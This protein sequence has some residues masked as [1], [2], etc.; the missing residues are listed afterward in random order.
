MPVWA[1]SWNV[2]LFRFQ[3]VLAYFRC[4]FF[5]LIS[6]NNC[7]TFN[8]HHLFFAPFAPSYSRIYIIANLPFFHNSNIPPSK[9]NSIHIFPNILHSEA[10]WRELR[11]RFFWESYRDR[12]WR[13]WGTCRTGVKSHHPF[14]YHA[15]NTLVIVLN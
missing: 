2:C 11:K 12:W 14:S 3:K 10:L 8:Q 7:L 5:G 4:C 1:C 9:T 13:R 6:T 15:R